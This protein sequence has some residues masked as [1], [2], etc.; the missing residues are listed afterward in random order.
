MAIDKACCDMAA[1][2]GRRFRG[3]RTIAYAERIGMGSQAHVLEE[4]E[5]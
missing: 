2:R 4:I 3:Q 5:T 1:E